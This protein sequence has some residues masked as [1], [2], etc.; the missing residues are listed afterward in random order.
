MVN[1]MIRTILT[2]LSLTASGSCRPSSQ[3][4]H[5][6]SLLVLIAVDELR[7]DLLDRCGAAFASKPN[8]RTMAAKLALASIGSRR[9]DFHAKDQSQRHHDEL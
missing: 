8:A 3:A 2:F 1:R 4:G 7:A 6:P 5:R 9:R